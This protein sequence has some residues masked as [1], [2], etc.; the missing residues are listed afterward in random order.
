MEGRGSAEDPEEEALRLAQGLV[1]PVYSWPRVSDEPTPLGQAG[2]FTKS[3]PLDFPM[4]IADLF[5][6][7]PRAVTPHEWVQYLLR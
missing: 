6:E 1:D 3:F 7:R 5:D 4:G 2:R